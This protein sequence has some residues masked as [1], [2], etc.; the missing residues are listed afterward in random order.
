MITEVGGETTFVGG[1]FSGMFSARNPNDVR[2]DL[3]DQLLQAL[4]D[5]VESASLDWEAFR[6]EHPEWT[7]GMFE[8]ESASLIHS[9]LRRHL[10]R[11]VESI[12]NVTAFNR[13]PYFEMAAEGAVGRFYKIRV[14]RH[15]A[16]DLIS[17]FPTPSD[18][19]FWGDMPSGFDQLEV[20]NL[21]FGYRWKKEDKAVGAAVLSYREGKSNPIWS[22][23]LQRPGGSLTAPIAFSPILPSLP[24]VDLRDAQVEESREQA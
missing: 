20:V 22:V 7:A 16:L 10:V 4:V 13:E 9:N 6:R 12:P 24:L 11:D 21:A 2:Y 5:A 17:S 3:P 18:Q 1:I 8:R 19:R 15:D 23:E 14:K